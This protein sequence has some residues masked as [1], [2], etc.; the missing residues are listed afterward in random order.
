MGPR[1]LE[2]LPFLKSK[3][4]LPRWIDG[5]TWEVKLSGNAQSLGFKDD[6]EFVKARKAN[7]LLQPSI[8]IGPDGLAYVDETHHF[9]TAIKFHTEDL[10]KRKSDRNLETTKFEN[11]FQNKGEKEEK[12]LTQA[13]TEFQKWQQDEKIKMGGIH[14]Q[15]VLPKT[16]STVSIPKDTDND[17]YVMINLDNL[18]HLFLNDEKGK[19]VIELVKFVCNSTKKGCGC[20]KTEC[21]NKHCSCRKAEKVCTARCFCRN[22]KNRKKLK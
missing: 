22:C 16:V 14:L 4:K 19:A 8:T 7:L 10:R 15:V 3:E 12:K 1:K 13:R 18:T 5:K 11:F 17:V 20:E 9:S 21:Q 6:L 2:D